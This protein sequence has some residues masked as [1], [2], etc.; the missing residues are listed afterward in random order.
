MITGKSYDLLKFLVQSF[1][2]ILGTLYF[3]FAP[4]LSLPNAEEVV[5]TIIVLNAL[6]GIFLS[7]SQ[8]KYN[9]EISQG[10]ILV[11]TQTDE[12]ETFNLVLADDPEVLKTKRE[13][14]F[15]IRKE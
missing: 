12:G 6:L 1:L 15:D 3:V 13:V 4:I 8:A 2:P 9:K 5:G 7:I 11:V 14:R 10:G